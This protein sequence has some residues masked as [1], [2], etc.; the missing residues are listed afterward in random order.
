MLFT[1]NRHRVTR[2]FAGAENLRKREGVT[3][4]IRLYGT[5]FAVEC[6]DFEKPSY[7][8]NVSERARRDTSGVWRNAGTSG[9]KENETVFNEWILKQIAFFRACVKPSLEYGL[10]RK[11]VILP[12]TIETH[13]RTQLR[14]RC[15]TKIFF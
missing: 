4:N 7:R 10:R 3:G 12:E 14:K 6:S 1:N 11:R 15:K 9:K 13:G 2:S 8:E 5:R